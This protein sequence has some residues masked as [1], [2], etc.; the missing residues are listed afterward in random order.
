MASTFR[1]RDAL[2]QPSFGSRRSSKCSP[3]SS[4]VSPPQEFNHSFNSQRRYA[5]RRWQLVIFL[6]SRYTLQIEPFCLFHQRLKLTQ[7]HSAALPKHHITLPIL[8]RS[9]VRVLAYR[10]LASMPPQIASQTTTT[11]LF[12]W[13]AWAVVCFPQQEARHRG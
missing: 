4:L 10:K 1:P 13:F 6:L 5:E 8:D 3:I 12:R 9:R 7:P 11:Y 2:P